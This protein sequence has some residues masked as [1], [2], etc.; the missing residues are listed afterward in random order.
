[1]SS[2]AEKYRPSTINEL[3][4]QP[5][6]NLVYEL[7]DSYVA[8]SY[9]FFGLAG[10]GKTSA[11]KLLIS[12]IEEKDLSGLDRFKSDIIEFNCGM[13]GN[14]EDIKDLITDKCQIP[15]R[16]LTR[17]YVILDEAQMLT[18]HSQNALLNV[19]EIPPEFLTFVLCTTEPK[20]LIQAV[21]SRCL[22][23]K[24]LMGSELDVKKNLT[25]VC[26][27]ESIKYD[28]NG[29][30]LIARA[31]QGSFR[32]ALMILSQYQKTGATGAFVGSYTGVMDKSALDDLLVDAFNGNYGVLMER[33][34]N[35]QK[36][37][38]KPEE[39]MKSILE[40][41]VEIIKCKI[42]EKSDG[43]EL[44]DTVKGLPILKA[45]DIVSEGIKNISPLTPD[46]MLLQITIFKLC[47]VK[48]K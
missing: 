38:I 30:D 16:Q 5:N 25:T 36:S 35:I 44:F 47:A 41:L 46:N 13:N 12:K 4:G 18:T 26:K 24:F 8:P 10:T 43:S 31:S 11:A 15:P 37:N 29:L 14:V 45:C 21:K 39:V 6:F 40:R 42:M 7:A 17:K 28:E 3:L 22:Q 20:K 1:M 19:M 33:I 34:N 27:K 9:L 48:K 32:E 23:I 2:L